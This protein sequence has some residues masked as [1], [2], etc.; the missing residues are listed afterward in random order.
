MDHSHSEDMGRG[1]R[2][3]VSGE[4]EA[5][6]SHAMSI[7][8]QSSQTAMGVSSWPE[9]VV[10]D[11][12]P[13]WERLT[14]FAR[15]TVIGRPFFELGIAINAEHLGG[16]LK[17][18]NDSGQVEGLA[19]DFQQPNGNPKKVLWSGYLT[20]E[21]GHQYLVSSTV[22]VT[23]QMRVEAAL[24]ASEYLYRDL[25]ERQG[26]GFAV[27]DVEEQFILANPVADDIFGVPRGGLV[28]R[29]LLEFVVS[30]QKELVQQQTME[31]LEGRKSTYEL[32]IRRTDGEIRTL[33]VTATPL[34]LEQESTIHVIGVFRDITGFK[35]IQTALIESETRFQRLLA[36]ASI[37][38]VVA[39]AS[40]RVESINRE[41]ENVFGYTLEELPDIETWWNRAYP[42]SEYRA[43]V[44]RN[45]D[46]ALGLALDTGRDI[47]GTEP[48]RIRCQN[49]ETRMAEI[50]GALVGDRLI[51]VFQDLTDRLHHEAIL[52][53]SLEEIRDA[54]QRLTFQ[55]D[56]MPL[57]YIVWDRDFRVLEWNPCAEQI[58]GW[59]RDEA[60][61]RYGPD[62]FIPPDAR[63]QVAR[64]WSSIVDEGQ[65]NNQSINDN[66]TKDGRRLVCEWFSSPLM[67]EK[68][69]ITGCLS[70][71]RNLT[72][73]KQAEEERRRLEQQVARAQRM[74][75]LGSL[76]GG[77]AHDMNNVLGAIMGLAELHLEQAPAGTGLHRSMETISKACL[78]GRTLVQ[79]ILS[80]ARPVI[81]E[82]QLLNLN[83][84]V[85]DQV[86]LLERTTLQKVRLELDLQE[87][88]RFVKGDPG[89]LSHVLMNLCVNAVDAMPEGGVLTLRTGHLG[90]EY[91][92]LE[93]AD[94]GVGMAPEV[95]EKALDPFF[96]TKPVG[97]GTGLGLSIVY[98]AVKAH[99]GHMELHSTP[100]QGTRIQ[101][102]LPA[103][104][105]GMP[106]TPECAAQEPIAARSL[107]VLIVDDDELIQITTASLIESLGH[108]PKV[109][110]SGEAALA[111]LAEG[112]NFHLVILD[113][114]MPGL[115]GV[116]TLPRLRM[117]RPDLPVIL[118]TG[119]AD[120]QAQDACEA[121]PG[122]MLL[123][124]P[125][126]RQELRQGIAS[127][128]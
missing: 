59:T 85:K 91:V 80:F 105:P 16:I 52:K 95:L 77:I 65:Q 118:A 4:M 109:A 36:S 88:L 106:Q 43:E 98:G 103:H 111:L 22:D 45:W 123:P 84:L 51:V 42:D 81:A 6:R 8:F 20:G 114:N 94:T 3:P 12:N 58:F 128:G 19:V 93:V 120:Q 27:V 32:Q 87:N 119:R 117:M 15:S 57:A 121:F 41:F 64:V 35:Q 11:V 72:A 122:V 38:I 9:I 113:M 96:T 29:C 14:G 47:E 53:Q 61:G 1:D 5:V 13:A 2:T 112:L 31:R 74:E 97:K 24:R 7:L 28:G 49:G 34:P 102:Q 125:F 82:E 79:G 63:A 66:L 100:G 116:E 54:H 55:I 46:R 30:E 60:F 115:S 17:Q 25:L 92:F 73:E 21:K 107:D 76:A 90:S 39:H 75:S 26:E 40:G 124:K 110:G 33:L 86:T 50:R 89:S 48:F 69:Q 37:P 44:K 71:A 10:L 78:R 127:I 108:R 70:M 83:T 101:I 126:T 56:H 23:D 99:R 68:G 18:L 67:D 104:D 62:L